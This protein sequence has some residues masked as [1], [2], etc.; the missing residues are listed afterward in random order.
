MILEAVENEGSEIVN[1]IATGC[2]KPQEDEII[3]E[4]E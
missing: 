3:Q 2:K 4:D 1:E